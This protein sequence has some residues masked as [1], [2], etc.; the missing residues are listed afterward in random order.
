M[1]HYNL[2]CKHCFEQQLLLEERIAHEGYPLCE[3]RYG[4]TEEWEA[5]QDVDFAKTWREFVDI[6]WDIRGGKK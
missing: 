4:D 2:D 5:D 6:L 3:A 1:S